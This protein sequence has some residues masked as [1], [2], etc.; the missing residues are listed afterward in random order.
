MA[1]EERPPLAPRLFRPLSS[2][3]FPMASRKST[4]LLLPSPSARLV[5]GRF[6][7]TR[8]HA[9]AVVNPLSLRSV[10]ANPRLLQLPRSAMANLKLPRLLRSVMDNPKPQRNLP[11]SRNLPQL[12]RSVMVSLR[13]QH[14]LPSSQ[15]LLSLRSAMVSLKLLPSLKSVTVSPRPQHNLPN[16]RNLLQSL[17]LAMVS[18][19]HPSALA[20]LLLPLPP[21]LPKLPSAVAPEFSLVS[22]LPLP[23]PWLVLLLCRRCGCCKG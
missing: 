9:A 20:L 10:M 22:Q 4:L 13:P 1:V 18:P 21:L 7:A 2:Q 16:S 19:R 8:L 12:P 11:S 14:N 17:R 3:P 6:K 23:S 15:N 5:T